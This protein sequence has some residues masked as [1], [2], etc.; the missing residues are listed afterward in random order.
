MFVLT[1]HLDN[2]PIGTL[3]LYTRTRTTLTA[4]DWSNLLLLSDLPV[5]ALLID[6]DT[7]PIQCGMTATTTSPPPPAS[8]RP[9]HRISIDDATTL[10]RAHTFTHNR[11]L[12][13]LAH[14]V[15]QGRLRLD[16]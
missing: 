5:S 8:P 2:D 16:T 7:A 12:L 1:L 13:D 4:T 14:D 11:P 15:I 10:I 9:A 6:R 3:T